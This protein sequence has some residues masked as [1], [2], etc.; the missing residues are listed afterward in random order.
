MVRLI[1]AFALCALASA[2]TAQEPRSAP[3]AVIKRPAQ[4]APA[5]EGQHGGEVRATVRAAEATEEGTAQVL[6]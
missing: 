4:A 1:I 5:T 6:P 2:A 3:P